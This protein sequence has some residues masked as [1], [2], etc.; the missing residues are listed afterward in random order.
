MPHATCHMPHKC[1]YL[2]GPF[3]QEA[4][5]GCHEKGDDPHGEGIPIGTESRLTIQ[6]FDSFVY[7]P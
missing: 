4:K 5:N 3:G 6:D 7:M 1:V 2:H